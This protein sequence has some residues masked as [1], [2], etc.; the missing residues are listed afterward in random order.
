MHWWKWLGWVGALVFLSGC[1]SFNGP[2]I[3]YTAPLVSGRVVNEASGEPIHYARV[4]RKLWSGRKG[5]GEFFKGG[6]TM[7]R[8]QEYDRTDADGRFTLP[9]REVALLFSFGEIALNLNLTVQHSGFVAWRT[10]FPLSALATN[11]PG[12]ELDAGEVRLHPR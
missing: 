5:T 7:L 10:N 11:S 12:L 1:E 2:G 9:A 4:G 8:L 6:E 3:D